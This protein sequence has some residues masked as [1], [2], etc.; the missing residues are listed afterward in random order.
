MDKRLSGGKATSEELVALDTV[1]TAGAPA[2]L[3]LP[4]LHALNDRIG[5]ISR[6]ALDEICR[7]LDLAPA[8]AFG[9][10]SFYGLFATEPRPPTVAYVCDDVPCRMAGALDVIDALADPSGEWTWERTPCLGLCDHAPAALLGGLGGRA[11]GDATARSV[12]A[13]AAAA[14]AGDVGSEPPPVRVSGVGELRLLARVNRVEP[15]DADA[16]A[17]AGGFAGLRRAREIGPE[18]VVAEITES[19]LIG[20]GGAAFPAGVKWAAVSASNEP[21]RFLVCNA[22]ESET[23]TFKDRVLL[24]GDPFAILEGMAI[25]AFACGVTTSYL[26]LRG[27]YP[28]ARARLEQA[29]AHFR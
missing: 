3:L 15:T 17:Q 5:W 25:A 10:A 7:R 2:D 6:G 8:T 18:A 29:I 20:R 11:L 23:G 26:Y 28:H 21:V 12:T 14:L 16:Y 13:A 24:E 19:G 22:D 1:I 4:A 27:E 9:V